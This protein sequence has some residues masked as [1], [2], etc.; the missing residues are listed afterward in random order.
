MK[1][2]LAIVFGLVALIF[3]TASVFSQEVLFRHDG[4]I[5]AASERLPDGTPVQWHDVTT[6]GDTMIQ[7]HAVSVDF[8]IELVIDVPGRSREYARAEMGS[9]MLSLSVSG[10][11]TIRVGVAAATPG[12]QGGY[13]LRVEASAPAIPV[14]LGRPE[15]G[16]LQPSGAAGARPVLYRYTGQSGEMVRIQLS[17]RDFDTFLTVVDD[18]GAVSEN[19]DA[20]GGGHEGTTDSELLHFFASAGTLLIQAGSYGGYG[21]GRFSLLVTPVALET[22]HTP[23][24]RLDEEE[25]VTGMMTPIDE[26]FDGRQVQR[27]TIG[28]T[29][30]QEVDILM[31]SSEFDAY[32]IAESPG[33][34]RYEDD[35]SGGGLDA[36]LVFTAGEAGV[37]TVY[38]ASFG[39]QSSGT[40]TIR[41]L[42][43]AARPVVQRFSGQLRE[44]GFRHESRVFQVH[45]FATDAGADYR[46]DLRSESFD[47]YLVV[48]DGAGRPIAENDD[49]GMS[50]DSRVEFRSEGGTYSVLAGAYSG[51][52]PGRYEIE[53]RR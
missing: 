32:L 18:T 34:R 16:I 38:A 13:S 3:A 21:S 26:R 46:V 4:R 19:D 7:V 6:P 47:T 11:G 8:P 30:G 33:G 45:T 9:A 40:Y 50:T 23:G 27:Y 42:S 43:R 35:D 10:A 37:W 2:R 36:Q 31:R 14:T 44:Q 51:T 17:S 41:Y 49:F 1:C 12:E 20:Y 5:T 53:I 22:T 48:L 25:V 52:P 28:V 39:S 15:A 24:R 29:A